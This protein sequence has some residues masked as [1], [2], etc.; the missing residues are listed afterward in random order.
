MA[1][2]F[3][4]L[5]KFAAAVLNIFLLLTNQGN[6]IELVE[7]SSNHKI[8][9]RPNKYD[10]VPSVIADAATYRIWWSGAEKAG[11]G[12]II[13]YTS[14]GRR[15]LDTAGAEALYL[16]C[17]SFQ[18]QVTKYTLFDGLHTC[19]PSVLRIDG[20]FYMYY[21]GLSERKRPENSLRVMTKL[22][23]ALSSDGLSWRRTNNGLPI[24]EPRAIASDQAGSYGLGQPSAVH[25]DSFFYIF[26]TDTLGPDGN[27]IY[28][29]RS[30]DPLLKV[31]LEFWSPPGF[32]CP[33]Q[34]DRKDAVRL[35]KGASVDA[36]YIDEWNLFMVVF[37]KSPGFMQGVFFDRDFGRRISQIE[38][39]MEWTEGPGLA[40]DGNG[41]LVADHLPD[42]SL[43]FHLFRSVGEKNKPTSWDVAVSRVRIKP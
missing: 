15:N 9:V 25:L 5:I 27:G 14:V 31:G 37:R 36:A 26:F 28:L 24:M 13:F 7:V 40:R 30:K 23:V 6:A 39:P 11:L 33:E 43:S 19:D 38:I 34:K 2:S 20:G 17:P 12:D 18:T 10:Y 22:G 21:G 16:L 42:G 41:W 3:Y 32:K 8:I 35:L 1:T 4:G 29:V